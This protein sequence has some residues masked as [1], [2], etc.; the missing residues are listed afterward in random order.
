MMLQRLRFPL[1]MCSNNNLE[2][3]EHICAVCFSILQSKYENC[4]KF[5]KIMRKIMKKVLEFSFEGYKI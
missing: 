3:M 2:M 4:L 1:D 5:K